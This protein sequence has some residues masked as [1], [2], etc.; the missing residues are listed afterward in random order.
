MPR[1]MDH[2]QIEYSRVGVEATIYA[3]DIMHR[4]G[5]RALTAV[6]NEQIGQ[7]VVRSIYLGNIAN[8]PETQDATILNFDNVKTGE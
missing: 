8:L 4:N 7:I 6:S 5:Y 2:D 3:L 1:Y